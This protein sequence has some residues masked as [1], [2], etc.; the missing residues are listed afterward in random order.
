MFFC[1]KV[2]LVSVASSVVERHT[3]VLGLTEGPAGQFL[4]TIADLLR[5]RAFGCVIGKLVESLS[6]CEERNL[7]SISD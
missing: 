4:R 3:S 6:M 7:E 5:E 1:N 2:V